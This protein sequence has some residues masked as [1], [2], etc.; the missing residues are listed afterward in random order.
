M[1]PAV[2]TAYY[3][4]G[5]TYDFSLPGAALQHLLWP[6]ETFLDVTIQWTLHIF[7]IISIL[8]HFTLRRLIILYTASVWLIHTNF[9]TFYVME[10]LIVQTPMVTLCNHVCV[11]P[12]I[13]S[14]CFLW[15]QEQ[16]S[17]VYINT[18]KL[19]IIR[20][21]CVFCAVGIWVLCMTLVER[22]FKT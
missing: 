18:F 17:I 16:I 3:T 1:S 4:S 12:S 15:F 6:G 14:V 9:D 21:I 22:V 20:M 8:R 7:R 2:C 11:L 13:L 10:T 19:F 5:N